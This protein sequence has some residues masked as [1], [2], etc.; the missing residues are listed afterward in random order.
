MALDKG[1]YFHYPS[2]EFF[3]MGERAGWAVPCTGATTGHPEVQSWRFVPDD[4][5]YG[6]HSATEMGSLIGYMKKHIER[7]YAKVYND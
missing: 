3:Y 5:I 4:E 7:V 1:F 6:H 2:R